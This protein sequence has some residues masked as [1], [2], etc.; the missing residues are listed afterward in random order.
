MTSK[1][2]RLTVLLFA[3]MVLAGCGTGPSRSLP[4]NVNDV[5]LQPIV[6]K[7]NETGLS[8]LLTDQVNQQ[9]LADGS[10]DIVSK[11]EAD[12]IIDTLITTY[13]RIPLAY[14]DQDIPQQYKVRM[15]LN[16]TLTDPKTGET[17][18]EF[19]NI[20]RETRYSDINPPI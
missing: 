17:L 18:R 1:T 5:Y 10:V 2:I 20:F 16:V 14:N 11:K 8:T 6:N 3:T 13:K 4:T 19:N 15:E 12:V 7:A 9:L